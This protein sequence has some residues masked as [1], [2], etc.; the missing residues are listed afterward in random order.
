M[1][2]HRLL[3]AALGAAFVALV[4]LAVAL[5]PSGGRIELP[6]PLEGVFPP[7]GD[8]VVRQTF[9]EVDLPAGYTLELVVDGRS[10]PPFEIASVPSTGEWRWQPAPGGS[11]EEW[12]PG[13][14]TVTI[15]WDRSVGRPDPGEF[16]WVFRVH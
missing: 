10:V 8:S 11:V 1:T 7:P 9:V 15:V 12:T 5:A 2:R 4:A 3:Y 16:T 6:E 13:E 14:H